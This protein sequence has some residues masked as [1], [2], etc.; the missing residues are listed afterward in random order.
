MKVVINKAKT[1]RAYP[2][3]GA[4][5]DGMVVLFHRARH[6]V[7]LADKTEFHD[8]GYY[9]DAWSEAEFAT[10]TGKLVLSNDS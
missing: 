1:A 10:F 9:S 5:P 6:G 7:V 3:I 8:P 2:Y 4:T